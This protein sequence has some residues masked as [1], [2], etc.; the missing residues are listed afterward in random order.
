[1][2]VFGNDDDCGTGTL[3]AGSL[4]GGGIGT[5]AFATGGAACGTGTLRA[6]SLR[7]VGR[8]SGL[9]AAALGFAAASR[10]GAGTDEGTTAGRPG[11]TGATLPV[12]AG[13][14]GTPALAGLR[15]RESCGCNGVSVCA[16]AGSAP[17]AMLMRPV[18]E[19]GRSVDA[20][21]GNARATG[22]AAATS[23]GRA[24]TDGASASSGAAL[25]ARGGNAMR[26]GA[27]GFLC[28]SVAPATAL[29]APGTL[30]LT[31]P[32]SGPARRCA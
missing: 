13:T 4:R 6:G 18:G 30:A 26:F 3:R 12:G 17:G 10:D 20:G 11:F 5:P 24:R 21:A 16:R 23:A 28:A 19:A 31:C 27:T 15:A 22:R 32:C 9:T 8:P 1:M 2:P 29:I 25:T 7:V 14:V